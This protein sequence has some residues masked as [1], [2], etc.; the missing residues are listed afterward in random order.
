[1]ATIPISEAKAKLAALV[2]EVAASG[3]GYVI[4]V[5]GHPMA[6]LR[7]FVPVPTPGR[8]KE[9]IHFSD[10]AFAPMSDEDA[11]AAGL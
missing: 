6:E 7:P 11:D 2:R 1:M 4:S 10:D 3:E 8:F 5:N 9:V